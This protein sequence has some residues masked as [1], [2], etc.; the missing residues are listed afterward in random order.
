MPLCKFHQHLELLRKR[1]NIPVG[2]ASYAVATLRARTG[3]NKAGLSGQ[4]LVILRY[5]LVL[6]SGFVAR[7]LVFI[8]QITCFGESSKKGDS[9]SALAYTTHLHSLFHMLHR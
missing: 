1:R 5:E 3:F 6:L 4:V 9:S 7:L 2:H 8:R